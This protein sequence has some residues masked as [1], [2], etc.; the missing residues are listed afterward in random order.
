[1]LTYTVYKYIY[2]TLYTYIYLCYTIA[3]WLQIEAGG[4]VV[5]N[6]ST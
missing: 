4:I 2:T 1:M 3:A 6:Y 5:L